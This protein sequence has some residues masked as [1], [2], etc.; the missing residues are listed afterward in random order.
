[1]GERG[2]RPDPEAEDDDVG[3]DGAVGGHHGADPV[4][5]AG[6]ESG[7]GGV[8]AHVHAEVLH[9]P[10]HR[11]P[12]VRV[13]RGHRLGG[14]ID[15]GHRDPAPHQGLGHLH[16]DVAPADHD[17]PPRLR[18]IKVR[19]ERGTVVEGLHPE[20]AGGVHP[21]QRRPDRDRAGGNDEG[22]EAFLVRT[23][24]A[25]VASD[26]P[27]SLKVDLLHRGSHPKVD[28]VTPV[29]V[30]HRAEPAPARRGPRRA[31][32]RT[33]RH[34]PGR[35]RQLRPARQPRRPGPGPPGRP[36][37]PGPRHRRQH[38][39]TVAPQPPGRHPDRRPQ[40]PICASPLTGDGRALPAPDKGG[41]ARGHAKAQVAL[42]HWLPQ[43]ARVPGWPGSRFPLTAW[44]GQSPCR[45]RGARP[46]P[47]QK[48]AFAPSGYA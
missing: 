16:A 9:G 33:E 26:H 41:Y 11:C 8:G 35:R 36:P 24:G 17:G 47:R 23:P 22:V 34:M 32:L 20:H 5:G 42:R 39:R 21:G 29:R 37:P 43:S 38:R 27:P 25:K 4:V 45:A 18:A 13:E 7:D 44:R 10:V 40:A 15:D 46:C 19:Q 31:R 14:L 28:T 12:H 1:M 3:G 48:R 30:R 2:V 6:L